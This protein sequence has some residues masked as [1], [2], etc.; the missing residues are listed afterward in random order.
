MRKANL[1]NTQSNFTWSLFFYPP[2]HSYVKV[3]KGRWIK[4]MKL[5]IYLRNL[6]SFVNWIF[7]D[8]LVS[9]NIH[10]IKIITWNL[11]DVWQIIFSS[12]PPN[13]LL[14]EGIGIGYK[15]IVKLKFCAQPLHQIY[16]IKYC[17][18]LKTSLSE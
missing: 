2:L 15:S 8:L 13:I 18:L 12:D 3:V 9:V 6:F 1:L 10:V 17:I 16:V 4:R 7:L 14:C 11:A 5:L